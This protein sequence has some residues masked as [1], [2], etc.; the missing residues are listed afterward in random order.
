MIYLTIGGVSRLADYNPRLIKPLRIANQLIQVSRESL[1]RKSVP[2]REVQQR[3]SRCREV[4]TAQ[5]IATYID[6]L[7]APIR[8]RFA[9]FPAIQGNES[10]RVPVRNRS[11]RVL[12]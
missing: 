12:G 6:I 9:N 5:D 7:V 10:I 11:Q 3:V 8:L 1:R 2:V 4:H